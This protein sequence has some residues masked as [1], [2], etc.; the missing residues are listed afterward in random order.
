MLGF[1]VDVERLAKRRKMEEEEAAKG[2]EEEEEGVL[3]KLKRAEESEVD[4]DEEDSDMDS[5]LDS[6]S[7][8]GSDSDSDTSSKPTRKAPPKRE[9]SPAAASTA[10]NLELT[11]DFL[12]QKFPGLFA[13][14]ETPKILITTSLGSILHEQ[15]HVLESIFPNSTYIRRSAHHV[16]REVKKKVFE[17]LMVGSTPISTP[18]AR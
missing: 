16:S 11:P 2:H 12:K 9:L 5:M 3:A 6:G 15:A 10:T 14:C 13:P 17:R 4:W 18:F 7:D 8:D 1:S